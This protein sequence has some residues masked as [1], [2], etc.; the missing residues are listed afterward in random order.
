[1]GWDGWVPALPSAAGDDACV[2]DAVA[3]VARGDA[4]AVVVRDDA[5]AAVARDDA[6]VV[7]AEKRLKIEPAPCSGADSSPPSSHV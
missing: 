2:A 3:A 6:V 5:V 7:P 4:V 1:V